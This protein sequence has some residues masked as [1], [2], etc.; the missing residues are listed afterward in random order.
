MRL[1]LFL[2]LLVS[3]ACNAQVV[4]LKEDLAAAIEKIGAEKGRVELG[5]GVYYLRRKP[6]FPRGCLISGVG[7][8]ADRGVGTEIMQAYDGPIMFHLTGSGGFRDLAITAAISVK[9]E[10]AIFLD[11][12]KTE[13]RPTWV[14]LTNV[15]FP[16]YKDASPFK[17]GIHA[18]GSAHTI[19]GSEGVRDVTLIN[20]FFYGCKEGSILFQRVVNSSIVAGSCGPAGEGRAK[21]TLRDCDSIHVAAHTLWGDLLVENSRN[22]SWQ[23]GRIDKLT[24]VNNV[25]SVFSPCNKPK[26]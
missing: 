22:V 19:P 1:I 12:T 13:I 26:K 8:Y 17:I 25:D 14:Q 11:G 10:T 15:V 3:S 9:A 4:T 6:K 20:C 23:G 2:L 24:T 21:I 16:G 18:D 7:G 5:K